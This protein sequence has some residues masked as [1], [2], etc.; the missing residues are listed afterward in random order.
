MYSM[1]QNSYHGDLLDEQLPVLSGLG[2]LFQL[3]LRRW[4]KFV[5]LQDWIA[6]KTL[7]LLWCLLLV[8]CPPRQIN[9]AFPSMVKHWVQ[10]KQAVGTAWQ[11]P[12]LHYQAM[13]AL[14]LLGPSCTTV[15]DPL[16]LPA[17]L[18]KPVAHPLYILAPRLSKSNHCQ[19]LSKSLPWLV[20]A[21]KQ[22]ALLLLLLMEVALV[23]MH[24]AINAEYNQWFRKESSSGNVYSDK[25][26]SNTS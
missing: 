21:N 6:L 14:T 23:A 18:L 26:I 24:R 9:E 4:K 5:L 11:A 1:Y 15:S 22:R 25:N 10:Q 17:K 20:V 13:L 16:L 19:M 7:C 12:Y 3:I 2:C 8:Q